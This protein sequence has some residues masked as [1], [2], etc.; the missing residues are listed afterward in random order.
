[1][2][3]KKPSTPSHHAPIGKIRKNTPPQTFTQPSP[4]PEEEDERYLYLMKFGK[5]RKSLQNNTWIFCELS[6]IPGIWIFYRLPS[7]REKNADKLSLDSLE[8]EHIPLLEGEEKLKVLSLKKNLIKNIENMV[9]LPNL[10]FLDLMC[11]KLVFIAN[12]ENLLNLKVLLIA[13]NSISAINSI[14][15]LVKL[16]VLDL[17]SN[18]IKRIEGLEK[19]ENL[20]ILNLADNFIEKI[21]GFEKLANLEELNLKMNKIA[22][23]ENLAFLKKLTKL[24]LCE[25]SIKNFTGQ[26]KMD[27][28][29]ELALDGNQV[30][31]EEN[32][33]KKI[34]EF[35]PNL[36]I[37]DHKEKGKTFCENFE[38]KEKKFNRNQILEIIKENWE[39]ELKKNELI[40]EKEGFSLDSGHAEIDSET[41]LFIYGN[42][43]K[44]VLFEEKYYSKIKKVRFL[45]KIEIF[46]NFSF[47]VKKTNF[48]RFFS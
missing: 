11:N 32:Y 8:L 14:E 37:L 19:L 41:S 36:K 4:P 16:E 48:F 38:D 13:E 3:K 6:Q 29:E 12:L 5:I 15:T 31:L 22:V 7:S 24:F 46:F 35:F 23:F 45:R 26:E 1:M 9:S 33:R 42:A 17:H 21:E 25:N 39:K 30:C 40:E 43:Y 10:L 27:L 47:F 44:V 2:L 34:L 20:K 28:L 18:K